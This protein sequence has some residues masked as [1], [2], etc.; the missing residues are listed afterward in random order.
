MQRGRRVKTFLPAQSIESRVAWFSEIIEEQLQLK[1]M[2]R[3]LPRIKN[4]EKYQNEQ[5]ISDHQPLIKSIY[6]TPF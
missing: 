4:T 2:G 6:L 3:R 5:W 1:R